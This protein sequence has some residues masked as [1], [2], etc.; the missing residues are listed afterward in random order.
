MNNTKLIN[1][2]KKLICYLRYQA[3]VNVCLLTTG[4]CF[5]VACDGLQIVESP[6]LNKIN[7]LLKIF[8]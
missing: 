2:L 4:F 7:S 3:A 5:R 8:K 1:A 6:L